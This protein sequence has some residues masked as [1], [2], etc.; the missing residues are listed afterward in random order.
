MKNILSY[1]GEAYYYGAVLEKPLADAYLGKLLS[2]VE[3]RQDEVVMFG[4]KITT[5]RKIAWYGDKPYRYT[6]SKTSKIA[7]PWTQELIELKSGVE[8]LANEEFNTCLLNLYHSGNEGMGWHSDDEPDLKKHGAIASLS[9]GAERKFVFKH[10]ETKEKAEVFLEHGSLLVMKGEV[11]T[12]WLHSL[13]KTKKV[14]D[15][16]V[17]LTFRTVVEQ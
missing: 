2:T 8:F 17:N 16:R 10:K 15:L 6:Y 1:H 3:W 11:Q 13:P 7:L 9:L 14:N 4:K 5:A 12:H